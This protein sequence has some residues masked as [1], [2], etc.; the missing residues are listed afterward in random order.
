[1]CVHP[2]IPCREAE[3]LRRELGIATAEYLAMVGKVWLL[4][5]LLAEIRKR[6][7]DLGLGDSEWKTLDERLKRVPRQ[8]QGNRELMEAIATLHQALDDDHSTF[9]RIARRL[10]GTAA[11][12]EGLTRSRIAPASPGAQLAS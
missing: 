5:D 9:A 1:M 11:T 7:G 3:L 4:Y 8:Y 2:E 12:C 6:R 10:R